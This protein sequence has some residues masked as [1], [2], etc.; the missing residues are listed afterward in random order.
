M[1][2]DTKCQTL[3]LSLAW[4]ELTVK[5]HVFVAE[6]LWMDLIAA[7]LDHRLEPD[8]WCGD[9]VLAFGH[10]WGFGL[11][12]WSFYRCISQS[13][14]QRVTSNSIHLSEFLRLSNS[15]S[16]SGKR[17]GDDEDPCCIALLL[18]FKGRVRGKSFL[19]LWNLSDSFGAIA[20]YAKV[21][22]SHLFK[23]MDLD[24]L[25]EHCAG[26]GLLG[27]VRNVSFL[28]PVGWT[29]CGAFL[30]I[31]LQN[32]M[33]CTYHTCSFNTMFWNLHAEIWV[34]TLPNPQDPKSRRVLQQDWTW[35]RET[36]HEDTIW[37]QFG[38]ALV[39]KGPKLGDVTTTE[40]RPRRHP[41]LEFMNYRDAF[42]DM[43]LEGA[44]EA[45]RNGSEGFQGLPSTVGVSL[46]MFSCLRPVQGVLSQ[47][48]FLEVGAR[49]SS[50]VFRQ[51]P[52]HCHQLCPASRISLLDQWPLRM[53]QTPPW[54]VD[55]FPSDGDA[56]VWFQASWACKCCCHL[57]L[58]SAI[59]RD[60]RCDIF[61]RRRPFG[62]D[63]HRYAPT[64]A[65]VCL[66]ASRHLPGNLSSLW[67]RTCARA[68]R[69]CDVLGRTGGASQGQRHSGLH[70]GSHCKGWWSLLSCKSPHQQHGSCRQKGEHGWSSSQSAEADWLAERVV[71]KR[72]WVKRQSQVP[73]QGFVLHQT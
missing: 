52:V 23:L 2:S 65:L 9:L 26:D 68:P 60:P 42:L 13:N 3:G 28:S 45:K 32:H 17:S 4:E 50:F 67:C 58:L 59:W 41:A 18:E 73:I 55:L 22:V 30:C 10:G 14:E 21:W 46:T 53:A 44:E 29:W 5:N 31:I 48:V 7:A 8:S 24:S 1:R 47:T 70:V 16:L 38:H 61:S 39:R 57:V 33:S 49:L 43:T 71:Q 37:M 64:S 27:S 19:N 54:D 15:G 40:N 56:V 35:I 34:G 11:F 63:S 72:G 51:H 25:P 20:S 62:F 69:V 36:E 12:S 66:G 6:Y